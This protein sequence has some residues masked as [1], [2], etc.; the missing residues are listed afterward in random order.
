MADCCP[1]KL[2][3]Q[4]NLIVNLKEKWE[5]IAHLSLLKNKVEEQARQRELVFPAHQQ[6]LDWL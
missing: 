3:G 2:N 4:L 5:R 6:M 1:E